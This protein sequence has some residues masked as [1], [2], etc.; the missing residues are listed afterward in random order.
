MWRKEL[1]SPQAS[2]T[3]SR[4]RCTSAILETSV[5]ITRTFV[6]PA[7]A[8]TS[9]PVS[10][11]TSS[12]LSASA[13]FKPALSAVQDPRSKAPREGDKAPI[14]RMIDRALSGLTRG[15]KNDGCAPCEFDSSGFSDAARGTGDD[16]D[17]ASVDDRMDVAIDRQEGSET[18]VGGGRTTNGWTE[19]R[20]TAVQGHGCEVE[21]LWETRMRYARMSRKTDSLQ[22]G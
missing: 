18:P 16:R 20:G 10:T 1:T 3:L 13:I 17:S 14:A 4:R 8:A 21:S 7:M 11:S 5:G 22:G 12:K 6:S 15:E 9:L 2:Y 19:R